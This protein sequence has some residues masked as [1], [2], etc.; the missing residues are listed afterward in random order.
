MTTYRVV[1]V[2]TRT[3]NYHVDMYVEAPSED[4]AS[5]LVFDEDLNNH[6]EGEAVFSWKSG[7]HITQEEGEGDEG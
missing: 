6:D 1:G 5:T 3:V 2:L 4:E 7:P